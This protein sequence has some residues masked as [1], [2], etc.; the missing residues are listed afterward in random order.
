MVV[1]VIRGMNVLSARAQLA[2]MSKRAAG[3]LMKLLDSA[4]ANA[5]NREDNPV[6][7]ENLVIESI[8]VDQGP[9]LKR[10]MPRAQGRAT[11]LRKRTSHISIVL[12]KK[13]GAKDNAS[14]VGDSK[15][16]KRNRDKSKAKGSTDTKSVNE[17]KTLKTDKSDN[18]K[19]KI[20]E[21]KSSKE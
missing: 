1:D 4:I 10:Y 17:E 21:K 15:S 5:E 11:P 3:P 14:D 8:T 16:D 13:K 9:T 20:D 7:R 12:G 2:S 19:Q 6:K 18:K